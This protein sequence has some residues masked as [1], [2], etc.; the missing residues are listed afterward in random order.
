[1][2]RL[3]RPPL[4]RAYRSRGAMDQAKEHGDL[5]AVTE[6][7]TRFH[8]L[9]GEYWGNEVQNDLICR[10]EEAYRS[11]SRALLDLGGRISRLSNMGR[12][13]KPLKPTTVRWP[14]SACSTTSPA[15][16]MIWPRWGEG[17]QNTTSCVR[18][19][20][21]LLPLFG[22]LLMACSLPINTL[23]VPIATTP[24]PL[25][26]TQE[27]DMELIEAAARGDS[28]TVQTLLAQGA[29]VEASD[30]RGRTAL[31]AAAYA[32]QVAVAELLIA[33]GADV[34]RKDQTQ[35][36]A[37]LIPTADGGLEFLRLMLDNGADVHS[38]DSYNGT[39]LI[40]AADRGHV[41]IIQELLQ[42]DINVNHVNRLGWTALL[43][44]IILGDGGPRHT[45]VV[46]LLVA[47][48]ADVNLTDGQGVTPL[49]HA[50]Q[51]G[52]Q[53]IIEILQAA[54]AE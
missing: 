1:M 12:S 9:I 43:E 28:E 15:S 38:T 24:T 21:W 34:N 31:I 54:G 20:R 3:R 33:A 17:K 13:S 16:A 25:F 29:N 30:S 44:A 37:Y 52:F 18:A 8:Y 36:S 46:R 47:A 4:M 19:C 22:G 10:I 26:A 11:S 45:E 35:Q 51:R 5:E 42:T 23:P 48:G 2:G 49:A 41:E 39:G 6:A 32:D 27:V 50:Q 40:R 53:P 7:D 14:R